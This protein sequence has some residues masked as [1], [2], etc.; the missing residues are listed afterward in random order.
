[1]L[2]PY[3]VGEVLQYIEKN[4][5]NPKALATF[6]NGHWKSLS[7]KEFLEEV[8]FAALGLVALGVKKG[9]KVGILAVPCSR[10][11]IADYA[12][13]AI[14]AVSVPIFANISTEHFIFEVTQP[15]I[16]KLFVFGE[17][18]WKMANSHQER[19]ELLIS[20]DGYA[21]KAL[22]Y[23]SLME[24]GRKFEKSHPG[25]FQELLKSL[26]ATDLATIIYTSGSTGVPKGAMHTHRSI[27]SLLPIDCFQLDSKRDTFLS[28]LP[29]A[30]VFARVINLM[31][32]SWGVAVYYYNDIK[33]LGNACKDIHPTIMIVVPR[34]LEKMYAK[35]FAKVQEGSFLKRTIG[36]YAFKLAHQDKPG[37]LS[38]LMDVLV[39]KHLREA[40]GGNLRVVIAGGAALNPRL[41][42]FFLNTGFPIFEG[43]GL[44]ECC[45][46][47]VN[48]FGKTKVGTVGPPLPGMM[49]RVGEGEELL[50]SGEMLLSGYF[51]DKKALDEEGWF[52]TGDKG[53]IDQ[54]GYVTIIGRIKE[55]FKTSTGEMVAPVPIEQALG[56]APWI[57]IP[58]VIA[59]NRK[60][61]SCLIFPNAESLKKMNEAEMKREVEKLI[62]SVNANLNEWEQIRDYRIVPYQLSV[63]TGELTPSMKIKR[64]IVEKKFSDLIDSIYEKEI[65]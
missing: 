57:E 41:Y 24:K 25:H 53:T 16:T 58:M 1:M 2:Q 4:H 47:T 56:K 6:E 34:I 7:T 33:T 51:G 59:D 30:H 15:G 31:M 63:E 44:T 21:G 62:K 36:N 64:E 17:E 13:M 23:E 65:S 48:Q 60:F 8:K 12:I 14:G 19:F 9:E 42:K 52:H 28:F 5:D 29:L 40:L 39:Y 46:V 38:P 20:L 35:M 26:K 61:V 10:W 22:S 55:L 27:S 43:W 54:E 45:P 18:Q 11:T 37:F 3:T 32:I 49:V 50:V